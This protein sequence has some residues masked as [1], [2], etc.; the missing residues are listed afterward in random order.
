MTTEAVPIQSAASGLLGKMAI[1][2]ADIKI[3]HSVFALPFA[4]LG[5]FLASAHG[6]GGMAGSVPG[7]D[8]GPA[9]IWTRFSGQLGLIVV[10][11]V[12]ARTWAMLVNRLADRRLDAANPRT[13]RRAFAS[14]R[15]TTRDGLALLG[16]SGLGFS[17]ACVL[18]G[19]LYG[20][21]WP[22]WGALPVLVWIGFYSFTKRFTAL[23]HVFLGGALATS[24]IAAAVA[25]AP[26]SLSS[27]AIWCL[28]GMVLFWVAGFDVIYALQDLEHDRGAGLCSVPS[29]LGAGRAIM[30]SRLLHAASFAALVAAWWTEPRLGV[31]FAAGVGATGVLLIAEH[32][33]LARR[34]KAGLDM[35]FF[36]LNGVIS[37]VLGLAGIA[38]V[39]V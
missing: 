39:L 4:A 22:A 12:F 30:I 8:T 33:V 20:N 5:A 6:G 31:V 17:A 35:A 15:L 24:P 18:F 11:M 38:D 28:S 14:G 2:A 16:L 10:C 7:G 37:V 32:V 23:C 27:P 1:V 19:V 9:I 26:G 13:A 34:G 21:W 25:V 3:A 36:T 29:R